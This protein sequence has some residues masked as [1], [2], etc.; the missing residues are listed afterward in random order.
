[1]PLVNVGSVT[2]GI[3]GGIDEVSLDIEMAVAMAP[4]LSH[5]YVY[6]GTSAD[7]V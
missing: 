2:P 6:E 7:S 5:I 3:N 4:G 1:M